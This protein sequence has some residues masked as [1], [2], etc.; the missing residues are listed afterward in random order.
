MLD[1][2]RFA[3]RLLRKSPLFTLTAA[4]SLAVGIGANTAIFSVANALLL[5]PLPGLDRPDRLVDLGRTTQGQGFDTVS[6]PYYRSVRERATTVSGIY[7][8]P[9]EPTAMS[10]GGRDAAERV[11]GM[12]VSGN[13]FDVLGTRPVYGRMLNDGDD[14]TIGGHPVTV[15]S[16]ELWER[17]FGADPAIVGQSIVLN[18][19]PFTIIGIAP[20][21][22]QG[23]TL[24]RSDLW[25]P[26]SMTGLAIPRNPIGIESRE[27]VWLVMGGRLKD[28][29]TTQQAQAEM[30]AIA[31][32]LQREL[33][34][35]AGDRGL[36]VAAS[37]LVP[38]Y[39]NMVAA[40]MGLLM[41]IVG[42]VLLIACVNVAGM[43]L[44]RA[45]NR[46]REIAVRLAVG[47]GR[48]RLIRQLM[49]EAIVL[50]AAGGAIGIVLSQWLTS[51]FL[52]VL[53][54]LPVPVGLDMPTD[55]RVLSFAVLLSLATAL[56]SGLVPALQASRANL[57]P[58]LKTE[59]MDSGASKLRLRSAFVVGQITMSL[60]LVI[61]AGLFLRALQHAASL[62]PG[63]NQDRVDVLTFDLSIGGFSDETGRL[64]V[65]EL[66][67]RISA[68][69]GVESATASVD[70]PLDGGRIGFGRIRQPGV[71]GDAGNID[72]DW[73]IVEPGFFKTLQLTLVRGRDFAPTDTPTSPRVAIVN[74]AFA[75]RVW[76]NQDPIGRQVLTDSGPWQQAMSPVTVIGVTVDAKLMSL[77]ET[78][79]PYIYVPLSQRYTSSMSILVKH[80]G[81]ASAIPQVRVLLRELSSNLPL[82]VALPLSDVTAIGLVPQRVVASVAGSLGIVGLVLAAIGIYGVTAYAVSRRTREIGIRV[83]L[84]ADE[85]R[86]LRLVLRQGLVLAG[87]GVAIGVVLAA[88]AS[89]FLESLL[90]GVRGLDPLTFGA[91]CALVAGVT[92]VATYVPARHAMR[93]D[94]MVALRSE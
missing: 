18:S 83:A 67:Q 17:R 15:I 65:R 60:L 19:H 56:V 69:P 35:E 11:Y 29:V 37:A 93:I 45:S 36:V 32:G 94:P 66:L 33:P 58:A 50:F 90:Y 78:A 46:R 34:Q 63:F 7:A 85:G 80:T 23:T 20:R 28:G 4:L 59:G 31:S 87:I 39:I 92:L 75:R 10:L 42:L 8:Y 61:A 5:R 30:N 72:A 41:A 16:H 25:V 26:L 14:K 48:G 53:P 74:E 51:M 77:N 76:P 44:A 49:I 43:M 47:A 81:N 86:V 6:H 64:F 54:A 40:F 52:A 3:V 2:I 57:V 21:G 71:D 91:A 12:V 79:T 24:L 9:L 27:S 62:Q 82:T 38:G 1:D 55:W 88:L 73:N 70:L 68:M 84:G 22:F 89:S 13:Y